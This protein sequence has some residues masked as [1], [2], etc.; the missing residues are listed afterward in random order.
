MGTHCWTENGGRIVNRIMRQAWATSAAFIV[1]AGIL[2]VV[3]PQSASAAQ[4]PITVGIVCSCTGPFAGQLGVGPPAYQAWAKWQNSKGGI[5]GHKVDVIVK[6]DALNPATSSTEVHALVTQNHVQALVDDSDVDAA[7]DAYVKEQGVPVI[8][9]LSFPENFTTNSDFFP[10]GETLDAYNVGYVDAAKAVKAKNIGE[11]YCAEAATCQEG[12]TAF[13]STAKALGLPASF[14]EAASASAPNYTAQCVA[15]QQAGVQ[16]LE[17]ALADTT[18]ASVAGDCNK[19]GYNPWYIVDPA[20]NYPSL[21]GLQTKMISTSGAIPFNVKNTPATKTM[22]A[23]L[24][25]YEPSLVTSGNF[26]EYVV[27]FWAAGLLLT[28]AAQNAG[29][30][31]GPVTSAELLKGLYKIKNDTLGGLTP[32]LTFHKGVPNPVD[33]WFYQGTKGGHFTTPFGLKPVCQKPPKALS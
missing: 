1:A 8:A 32:A 27:Q 33:C 3:S 9:G 21:P 11:V 22:Y 7:W 12:L 26:N 16:A 4:P 31:S 5:D 6:D 17:L 29:L 10:D 30:K 15:A 14:S 28:A 20:A 2:V 23:A 13:F 24:N 25:K 19:Q 18:A